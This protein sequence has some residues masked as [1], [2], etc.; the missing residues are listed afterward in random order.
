LSLFSAAEILPLKSKSFLAKRMN[1][2]HY[3]PSPLKQATVSDKSLYLLL[4][5]IVPWEEKQRED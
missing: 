2:A 4:H 3:T 1:V 5:G